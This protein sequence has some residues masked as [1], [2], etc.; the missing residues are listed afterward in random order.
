MKTREEAGGSCESHCAIAVRRPWGDCRPVA[1]SE[2][3]GGPPKESQ[4][5]PR[6][7]LGCLD[8]PWSLGCRVQ[9][10]PVK[11]SQV[12]GAGLTGWGVG[13]ALKLRGW[14]QEGL[15]VRWEGLGGGRCLP[16]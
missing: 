13:G 15:G 2:A 12:G 10:A 7:Q 3:G 4:A 9:P 1:T 6:C 14:L 11:K 5:G 16:C 8:F